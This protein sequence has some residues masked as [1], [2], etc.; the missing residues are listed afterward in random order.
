MYP[1]CGKSKQS[2]IDIRTSVSK[3]K[4]MEDLEFY[5]YEDIPTKNSYTLTNNGHS[6]INLLLRREERG[7]KRW[8][9]GQEVIF[10]ERPLNCAPAVCE[11]GYNL[12]IF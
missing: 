10:L 3:Y 2:P 11:A 4:D 1:E 6:G 9:K 8:D 5:G 12:T 7:G